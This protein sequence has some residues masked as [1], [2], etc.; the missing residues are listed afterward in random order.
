MNAGEIDKLFIDLGTGLR[1]FKQ[2]FASEF[3]HRVELRTPVD[4]GALQRG[5]GQ[6]QRQS[7]FDIWNTK[8]YAAYVEY[9]TPHHAPVGMI[10][11]TLV[12]KEQIAA[13]AKERSGLK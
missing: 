10:S 11:T 4:T 7:G 3:L 12:E 5:W 13:I 8:D 6:T 9:G 2:E 1:R